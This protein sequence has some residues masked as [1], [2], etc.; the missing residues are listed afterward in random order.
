[1]APIFLMINYTFHPYTQAPWSSPVSNPS[2]IFHYFL[3]L[4]HP[5]SKPGLASRAFAH[6]VPSAWNGISILKCPGKLFI[7][8]DSDEQSTHP[9]S[10][11]QRLGWANTCSLLYSTLCLPLSFHL[12]NF[13]KKHPSMCL[14]YLNPT[15]T[16]VLG[17][18]DQTVLS[19]TRFCH[20]T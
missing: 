16:D 12:F 13:I 8:W 1:M 14:I 15:H 19:S 2:F 11:F 17:A 3:P 10:L 6:A 20:Y 9:R 18:W 7:F 5:V 4:T